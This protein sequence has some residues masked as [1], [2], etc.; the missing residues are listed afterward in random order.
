MSLVVIATTDATACQKVVIRI[1]SIIKY[2]TEL[3]GS[4]NIA[5]GGYG[6]PLDAIDRAC[7][8]F[9]QCYHCL[10]EQGGAISVTES[11]KCIGEEVGYSFDLVTEDGTGEK[12]IQCTNRVGT[13]RRNVCECDRQLA[14]QFGL[15]QADWDV[16]L[17]T[18]RGECLT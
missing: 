16:N 7:F 11:G 3:T 8:D 10:V 13:C 18:N 1:Y 9:K 2:L 5:S 17:H 14:E 15:N 4:H 12:T 6:R